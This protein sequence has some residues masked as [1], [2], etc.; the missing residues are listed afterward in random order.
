MLDGI[1]ESPLSIEQLFDLEFYRSQRL[2]DEPDPV[3]FGSVQQGINHFDEIGWRLGYSPAR[4]FDTG[5]YLRANPD[6]E[7]AGL[8]PLSHYIN[9]GQYD[10]R[11]A[12]PTSD[13]TAILSERG[14][15]LWSRAQRLADKSTHIQEAMHPMRSP[16][17]IHSCTMLHLAI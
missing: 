12:C 1:F 8:N 9:F 13:R 16:T 7:S 6:V 11:R 15:K 5:F 10:G 17:L 2:S 4:L 3:R 14:R